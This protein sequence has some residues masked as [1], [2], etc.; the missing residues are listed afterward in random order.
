MENRIKAAFDAVHAD[1]K[2][3][4][5]TRAA[6]RKKSFDY[7]R[8]VPALRM[9]KMRRAVCMA[10]LCIALLGA[11]TY[12]LPTAAIDIDINPSVELKINAFDKVIYAKGL[13]ADGKELIE[14]MEL[15]NLPYTK[16]L[17]RIMLSDKMEGYLA[18]GNVLSITVV[19]ENDLSGG[20]ILRNAVCSASAVTSAENIY[21]CSVEPNVAKAAAAENLN[22]ARYLALEQLRETDPTVTAEQV[23]AMDMKEVKLLI[24]CEKLDEPCDYTK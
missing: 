20:E 23:A 1:E 7:G 17:R 9:R 11:G 15:K 5:H 6:L 2:V 13:N 19:G 12:S 21:Y 3:V 4:R 18:G 10:M 24:G 16:A 8:D 22:V 14:D